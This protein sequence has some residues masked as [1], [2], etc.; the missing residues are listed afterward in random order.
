MAGW[1]LIGQYFIFA[2][3]MCDGT[4]NIDNVTFCSFYSKC[5]VS[6]VF[7]MQFTTGYPEV[8]C[9]FVCVTSGK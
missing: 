6:R 9:W 4:L 2:V 5:P 1:L 7:F 8:F 3:S